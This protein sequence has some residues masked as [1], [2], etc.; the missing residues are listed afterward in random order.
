DNYE[1][2]RPATE[3]IT[4]LLDSAPQ[5]KLLVTTRER[6]NLAAEWVLPLTGLAVPP[7]AMTNDPALYS[8]VQL[9]V[10]AARRV[11]P[12]FTLTTANGAAVV[13]LCR[14][15]DGNPLALELAAGWLKMMPPALIVHEVQRNLEILRTETQDVPPRHRSMATVFEQSWRLLSNGERSTLRQLAIFVGTFDYAA[16][17]AVTG[18]TLPQLATLIDKSWIA[19]TPTGRLYLHELVRQFTQE[20]LVGEHQLAT[21]E[22]EAAVQRRHSQWYGELLHRMEPLLQGQDQVTALQQIRAER[23]NIWAAWQWAVAQHAVPFFQAAAFPLWYAADTLGWFPEAI[24]AYTAAINALRAKMVGMPKA[25]EAPGLAM[26]LILAELLTY[27]AILYPRCGQLA[28]AQQNC[29]E[30]LVHLQT[31]STTP[32]QQFGMALAQMIHGWVLHD[33][34]EDEAAVTAL[35]AA[36]AILDGPQHRWWLG[37]AELLLGL[38]VHSLGRHDEAKAHFMA[39]AQ[40]WQ[41]LGEQR[42]RCFALGRLAEL[43]RE[44]GD[45]TAAQSYLTEVYQLRHL[46]GDRVGLSYALAFLGDTA[47]A[48]GDQSGA[49]CWYTEAQQLAQEL[50]NHHVLLDTHQGLGEVALAQG[51]WA[52]AD[53]AFH[54]AYRLALEAQRPQQMVMA[55]LGRSDVAVAQGQVRQ[56]HTFL[57]E[58]LQLTTETRSDP[59][60]LQVLFH[61]AE[62]AQ[63]HDEPTEAARLLMLICQHPAAASLLQE[64]ATQLLERMA[65][66][67]VALPAPAAAATPEYLNAVVSSLLARRFLA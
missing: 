7:L 9:F 48:Q 31:L 21:G 64:Q 47:L 46:L 34:A 41:A 2:L 10:Q 39:A 15:V 24:D 56:A 67:G 61:V 25:G 33:L 23:T 11:Q 26:S 38:A 50:G 43:A 40:I 58:A 52:E 65:E 59:L 60:Q 62:V 14:L 51:A 13:H 63:H 66:S 8:A 1:H 20:K 42:F 53:R 6:L 35:A 55:L 19:A 22:T 27:Q 37:Q 30:A 57:R 29:T 28:Q 44:A 5:I 45:L 12:A 36:R 18:A 54:A 17:Q 49:A 16:A 3:L 4:T 32:Q